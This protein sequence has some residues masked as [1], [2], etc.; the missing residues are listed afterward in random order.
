MCTLWTGVKVPGHVEPLFN[1][2]VLHASRAL[3]GGPGLTSFLWDFPLH[4]MS[5]LI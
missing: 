4:E 3:K 2:P 1:L 5:M